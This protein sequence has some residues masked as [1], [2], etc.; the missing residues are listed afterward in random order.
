VGLL[1][2]QAI[3]YDGAVFTREASDITEFIKELQKDVGGVDKVFD[4][5]ISAMTSIDDCIK[6]YEKFVAFSDYNI[7]SISEINPIWERTR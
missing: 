3:L 4:S 7:C 1:K 2:L 5:A 6:L